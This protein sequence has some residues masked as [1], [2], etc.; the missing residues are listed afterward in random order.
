MPSASSIEEQRLLNPAFC[1]YLIWRSAKELGAGSRLLS[2]E[3]AFL[4]LPFVL[5]SV[6]RRELPTKLTTT[7]ATWIDNRPLLRSHILVSAR[8]LRP[9][10]REALLFAGVR[11][12]LSIKG[13]TLRATGIKSKV[14]A[15]VLNNSS[16]EVRDCGKRAE[17][18]GKWFRNAGLPST[19]F[20]LLGARP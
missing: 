19:V 10:T 9:F 15:A 6:V 2:L 3:E 18:V 8:A 5:P 1:A 7:L 11:G 17:F 13:T 4:T 14:E 16:D 20:A 12:V